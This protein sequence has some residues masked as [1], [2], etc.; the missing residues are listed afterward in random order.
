MSRPK[1]IIDTDP[2]VDDVMALLLALSAPSDEVDISLISVT[3]SNVPRTHCA[4][5]VLTLFNVLEKELA[6]RRQA[7]KLEGYQVLQTSFPI[8]SLGSEHPFEGKNLAADYFHGEDA[9]KMFARHTRN[10]VLSRIGRNSSRMLGTVPLRP[11]TRQHSACREMLRLLRENPEDSITIVAMG[12]LTNVALAAA[13]DPET[14]LRVKELVVMGGAVHCEGNVTPVAEFNCYA[15]PIAAARLELTLAPLD[16]TLP[17]V[18]TKSYFE[19]Q[20][21]PHVEAGRPLALWTSSFIIATFDQI[22]SLQATDKQPGLSLHD[23][24]TIWYAMTRDQGGGMHVVDKRNKKIADEGF[25]LT[26]VSSEATDNILGDDMGWLKPNQRNQDQSP[27][28]VPWG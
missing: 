23:Q 3:Y 24:L 11:S 14:F 1:L 4:R 12:P 18:M 26:G 20:I 28:Q 22:T 2:G 19:Q 13:E 25:T 27:D 21:K 10:S 15:D 16:I 7:G 5:N 8:F 6:W 17:H 9:C